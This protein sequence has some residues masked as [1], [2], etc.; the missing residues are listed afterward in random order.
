MRK[1]DEIIIHCTATRPDQ[2]ISAAQIHRYHK[3][4]GWKGIGYHFLIRLDGT[5]EPGRPIELAGA[6]TA[7]HNQRTIGIAYAGGIIHKDGKTISTDTRNPA[8]LRALYTLLST[9]LIIYPSIKKI[10]GH[11]DYNKTSCPCFDAA[12]EYMPLLNLIR[13][14][15]ISFDS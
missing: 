14:I 4:Q 12:G 9:L 3:S 13:A 1:I 6:H 2:D 11:R 8:Q 10:S 5:I 7:G 15:T